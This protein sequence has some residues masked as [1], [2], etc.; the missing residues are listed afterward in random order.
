M[1]DKNCMVSLGRSGLGFTIQDSH[2]G[3]HK[4]NREIL[5]YIPLLPRSGQSNL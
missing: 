5:A 2:R 4:R 3:G 1:E